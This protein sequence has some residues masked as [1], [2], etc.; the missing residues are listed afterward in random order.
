M[1]PVL[2]YVATPWRRSRA[3][4]VQ[5]KCSK[6]LIELGCP[7]CP[8]VDSCRVECV[9]PEIFFVAAIPSLAREPVQ[10]LVRVQAVRAAH[11]IRSAQ[12]V[13]RT[14]LPLRWSCSNNSSRLERVCRVSCFCRFSE[15]SRCGATVFVLSEN[16]RS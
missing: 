5:V 8:V 16:L 12:Q 6:C 13:E 7:V 10:E 14:D 9:C 1:R 2:R 4:D 11:A 3:P 15:V